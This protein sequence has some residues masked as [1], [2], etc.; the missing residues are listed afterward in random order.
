MRELWLSSYSKAS[1]TVLQHWLWRFLKKQTESFAPLHK[2]FSKT[3]VD[4]PD[5]GAS[6]LSNMHILLSISEIY[7]HIWSKRFLDLTNLVLIAYFLVLIDD[8]LVLIAR[9]VP[10]AVLAVVQATHLHHHQRYDFQ[11]QNASLLVLD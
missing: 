2:V 1:H 7:A 10:A 6:A 8:F 11:G 4:S 3:K 9:L 5:S